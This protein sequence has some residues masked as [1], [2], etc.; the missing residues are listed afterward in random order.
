LSEAISIGKIAAMKAK[1]LAMKRTTIKGTDDV[2][3]GS[4]IRAML[5]F[6]DVTM[7]YIVSRERQWKTRAT[8]LQS[9]GKVT[10]KSLLYCNIRTKF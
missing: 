5:D 8:V 10:D 9:T 2:G 6:D 4:H 7:K 1:C 3:L